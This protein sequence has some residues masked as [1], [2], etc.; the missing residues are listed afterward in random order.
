MKRS[1]VAGLEGHFQCPGGEGREESTQ[2]QC[3]CSPERG[4][5]SEDELS[6]RKDFEVYPEHPERPQEYLNSGVKSS[7]LRF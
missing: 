6:H 2:G 4:G 1:K 7:D 5:V 3:T